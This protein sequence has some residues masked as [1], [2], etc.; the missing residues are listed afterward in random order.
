VGT[1][2]LRPLCL[3]VGPIW[4]QIT[5]R[6]SSARPR[7]SGLPARRCPP[8]HAKA[9]G[10]GS[11]PAA[12]CAQGVSLKIVQ[13]TLG[14]STY[15]ITADIY[16]HVAP[17]LKQVAADAI[18]EA[19]GGGAQLRQ[20]T[21]LVAPPASGCGSGL[22]PIR[23]HEGRGRHDP[24]NGSARSDARAEARARPPGRMTGRPAESRLH[25]STLRSSVARDSA[26]AV[27]STRQHRSPPGRE[28]SGGKMRP[29][30]PGS[31]PAPARE[32]GR[33][34]TPPSPTPG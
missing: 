33:A 4:D 6:S 5:D 29:D 3:A 16:A 23:L 31:S 9:C 7:N 19:L 25:T 28:S 11:R 24:A 18:D 32:A 1:R 13:E 2:S 26:I 12:P 20:V 10:M 15:Q 21:L 14:H 17:E 27:G 22:R 8:M 34:H 30:D